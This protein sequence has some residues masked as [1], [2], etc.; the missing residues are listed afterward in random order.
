MSFTTVITTYNRQNL[1]ITAIYS[2]LNIIPNGE[3]VLV[4]DASTDDTVATIK[5]KFILEIAAGKLV[6]IVNEVNLGVTGAKNEGYKVAKF[7]WVIFLD[8]DD[9][10]IRDVGNL[11]TNEL[12]SNKTVPIVFFR[13][14]DQNGKFVGQSFDKNIMLDLPTY[15]KDTTYGETLVAIN[16]TLIK[17]TPYVAE[18]RGYEGLGC[19]GIIQEFG[20]ALLS[21]IIARVYDRSGTNRLSSPSYFLQ[22]M[23]MIAKGHFILLKEFSAYMKFNTMVAYILKGCIYYILGNS[24]KLYKKY[25][26][27]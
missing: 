2:A 7:G 8:S 1:V 3:V 10:Y 27:N 14:I 19:Y 9:Y 25:L 17:K 13:C 20:P 18:L 11:I 21:T 24:F 6:L 23:P 4:D 16:K 12:K 15:I 26:G 5:S 22:R